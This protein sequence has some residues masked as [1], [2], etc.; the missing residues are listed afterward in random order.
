MTSTESMQ[1]KITCVLVNVKMEVDPNNVLQ[2]SPDRFGPVENR[3][4]SKYPIAS[5]P[6]EIMAMA[7]SPLIFVFCPVRSSKMAHKMVTGKI[8]NIL[9]VKFKIDATAIAPKAT[10]DKQ[11]PINEKRFNTSVTPS[12]EEHRAIRIPTISAYFTNGY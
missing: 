6:T 8:N 12:R 7:A 4:I 5:A 11:S 2:T 10:W 3:F 9:F 1:H